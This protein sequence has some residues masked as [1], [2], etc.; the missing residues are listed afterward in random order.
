MHRLSLSADL[1]DFEFCEL[2]PV[3]H[4][5]LVVLLWLEFHY[6]NLWTAKLF[7]H[8]TLNSDIFEVWMPQV[9]LAVLFEGQHTRKSH[10]VA[11]FA[12]LKFGNKHLAP[13]FTATT[14]GNSQQT[15]GIQV[16]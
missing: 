6:H 3:A 10:S 12:A 14:I 9:K 16:D 4:S 13:A 1:C 15:P 7:E 5:P 11:R 8:V 2:L